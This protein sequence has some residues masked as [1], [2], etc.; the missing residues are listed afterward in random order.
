MNHKYHRSTIYALMVILILFAALF[1]AG[2]LS[3]RSGKSL[4]SLGIPFEVED[5]MVMAL[6]V[7]AIVRVVMMLVKIEHRNQLE[8]TAQ[9]S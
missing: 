3:L 5:G 2:L 1:A 9:N 4:F 7:I 8:R 6:S